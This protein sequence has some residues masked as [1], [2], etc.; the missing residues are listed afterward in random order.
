MALKTDTVTLVAMLTDAC[1]LECLHCFK[2]NASHAELPVDAL[3]DV[4][5]GLRERFQN[6]HVSLSGGEPTLHRQLDDILAHLDARHQVYHI[7]TNGFNFRQRALPRLIRR[8]R[9]L[10]CVAFSL[11]G[12]TAEAHD[13]IR[14]K[15]SFQRVMLALDLC[16]RNRLGTRICCTLNK[17][18]LNQIDPLRSLVQRKQ[19][20]DGVYLWAAMPTRKL[21]AAGGLLDRADRQYLLRRAP[22]LAEAGVHIIGDLERMDECFEPCEPL[23]LR[24]FTLNAD[25]AMSLCCNLTHYPDSAG[26]DDFLGWVAHTPVGDLIDRHIDAA[27]AYRK[28]MLTDPSLCILGDEEAYACTHCARAHG[29][30]NWMTET[31]AGTAPQL[32]DI[33]TVSA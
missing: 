23:T 32:L 4:L 9:F 8:R 3:A 29:K 24:Q 27:A 6:V 7:V 21:A 15:G 2:S 13:R 1:N 30:L 22:G 25:G 33:V 19:I 17:T 20:T 12:G 26:E 28:R 14:G 31:S 5:D 11:D 18:N 16:R 10:E